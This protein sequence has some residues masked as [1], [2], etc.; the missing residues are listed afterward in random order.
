[1]WHSRPRHVLIV[2]GLAV[3]SIAALPS[4]APL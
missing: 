2:A 4:V 3:A 1:M